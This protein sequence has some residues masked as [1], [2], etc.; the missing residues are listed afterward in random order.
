MPTTNVMQKYRDREKNVFAA[1]PGMQELTQADQADH[2]IISG[3]YPDAVF[4]ARI[5]NELFRHN[6]EISLINQRA[7]FAI[8]DGENVESVRF[9]YDKEVAQ[10]LKRHNW[11]D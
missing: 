7:Y 9:R 8:L 11:D 2:E 4:A 3:Q 10:F 5:A 6:R 1:I